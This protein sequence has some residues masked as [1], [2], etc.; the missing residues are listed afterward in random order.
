MIFK[1]NKYFPSDLITFECK[2][3]KCLRRKKPG[4]WNKLGTFFVK[5]VK[6]K[7]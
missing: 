3:V 7:A 6:S 5:Q 4:E 1:C 2:V